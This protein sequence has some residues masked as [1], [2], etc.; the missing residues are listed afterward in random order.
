MCPHVVLLYQS[1]IA[2]FASRFIFCHKERD[3]FEAVKEEQCSD[4]SSLEVLLFLNVCPQVVLL[5]ESNIAL[6]AFEI[7]FV[8][9]REIREDIRRK[10]SFTFGHCLI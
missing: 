5:D 6:F 8:I 7:T 2:P 10:K 3:T 1:Y 4:H 9:L